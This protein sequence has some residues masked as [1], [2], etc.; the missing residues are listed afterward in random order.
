M[1]AQAPKRRTLPPRRLFE[2]AWR[3]A[4]EHKYLESQKAG[5]DL[6]IDAIDAWHRQHWTVW[7]RHRWIEHLLGL[8]CWEEFELEKFGTLASLQ[9]S[10]SDVFDSV[11]D[12]A[13]QGEENLNIVV[14][15]GSS[16]LALETVI[17]I[18]DAMD[19]NKYRCTRCCLRLAATPE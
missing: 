9:D 15:A 12:R 7:L 5:E 3:E 1:T 17:D 10:Y 13:R 19:L 14:W 6:G 18:L 4:Q 11:A 16:R 2:F 8:V